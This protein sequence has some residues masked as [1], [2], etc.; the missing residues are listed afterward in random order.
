MEERRTNLPGPASDKAAEAVNAKIKA[1]F[2]DLYDYF[3]MDSGMDPVILFEQLCCM[4]IQLQD[5]P[6]YLTKD[7]SPTTRYRV[8]MDRFHYSAVGERITADPSAFSDRPELIRRLLGTADGVLELIG[9][10]KQ[11]VP[12]LFGFLETILQDK[13][14]ETVGTPLQMAR[15]I[16]SLVRQTDRS[17]YP[18]RTL[19]PACGSGAFLLAALEQCAEG[20]AFCLGSIEGLERDEHLRNCVMLMAHFYGSLDSAVKVTDGG[21]PVQIE[22]GAFDFILANP[23]FRTQSLRDREILGDNH[24]LPVPTKDTHR[25]FLQRTLLGLRFGGESAIIVP[26]SFLAHTSSDAIR[27]RRWMVE[28][29]Q[30]MGVVKLPAYTFFPQAAVNA[31]IL[32]IR[33][34]MVRE[35]NRLKE[36]GVFFFAVEVDGRSNDTRRLPVLRNDFDELRQ[37]WNTRDALWQEWTSEARTQNIYGMD[38][39]V[40]W[41]HPQFWFG[42]LENIRSSDYSLLPEQYQPIRMLGGPVQDPGE[43]L[44]EMQQLGQEIMELMQQLAEAEYDG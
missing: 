7:A 19:D 27:V 39:P 4:L 10:Q 20:D 34:P 35:Q 37:V 6:A 43:I 30:C 24:E 21:S 41:N 44:D 32:F 31:S 9:D 42:S 15:E 1:L 40:Q 29:F 3:R 8:L 2:M 22:K 13:K 28:E 18:S 14:S 33:K 25:A 23:P 11:L 26:D 12:P 36:E 17:I 5:S 38:V 16:V